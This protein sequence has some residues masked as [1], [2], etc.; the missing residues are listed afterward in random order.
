MATAF[1]LVALIPKSPKR[2][3]LNNTLFFTAAS[4]FFLK[5]GKSITKIFAEKNI[6]YGKGQ[7]G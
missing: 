7:Y 2:Y 1:I 4:K 5:F 6:K 3:T